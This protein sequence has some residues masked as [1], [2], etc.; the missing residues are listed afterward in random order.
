MI[1]MTS[2]SLTLAAGLLLANSGFA[3]NNQ[4][5]HHG[6]HAPKVSINQMQSKQAQ[7]IQRGIRQ[8]K[9]TKREA[10]ALRKEQRRIR[11]LKR[12]F[13]H[14]G[15]LTRHERGQL[16]QMLKRARAHIRNEMRDNE[17]RHTH[18]HHRRNHVNIWNDW[19][20]NNDQFTVWTY[21]FP[22]H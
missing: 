22:S 9:I 12:H 3:H 10:R 5:R 8:G 16:R 2:L 7:L 17:T 21:A 6:H 15:R 4:H 1:K 18:R 13:R 19:H 11:Q 14:D 20:G